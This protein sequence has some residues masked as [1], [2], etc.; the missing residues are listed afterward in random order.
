MDSRDQISI[1][2]LP[3]EV[4][5]FIFRKLSAVQFITCIPLVCNRWLNIIVSDTHTLNQIGMYHMNVNNTVDFFFY[6]TELGKNL[7]FLPHTYR[8]VNTVRKAP[9]SYSDTFYLCTQFSNIFGYIKT[10]V[11]SGNLNTYV[12][13]GFT[14]VNNITT[15]EFFDL[16]IQDCH[17]YTLLELGAVYPSVE[18]VMYIQCFIHNLSGSHYLHNGF[19]RLK[20]FRMDHYFITQ[21]LLEDLLNSHPTIETIILNDFSFLDDRWF[22]V[23]LKKLKGQRTIKNLCIH[24][25]YV[26]DKR[27][28]EFLATSNLFLDKSKV[29]I[30]RN[31]C[32]FPFSISI[33]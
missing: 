20:Q 31:K 28:N 4:L 22:D 14:Y 8:N 13:E 1:N 11:I 6:K 15:I 27:V 17:V 30:Y 24:S 3:D 26:T 19:K 23:L 2:V 18:N 16:K 9:I 33:D 32:G 10:L 21:G 25:P 5:L 29:N 7:N 12:I